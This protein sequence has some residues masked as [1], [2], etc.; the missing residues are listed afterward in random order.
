MNGNKELVQAQ[1]TFIPV[2]N[3]LQ[4]HCW[5]QETLRAI[6]Q[7]RQ[8]GYPSQPTIC[9]F[10]YCYPLWRIK[11]VQRLEER[12]GDHLLSRRKG[13]R[14]P[15]TRPS[16]R[17]LTASRLSRLPIHQSRRPRH[18][19]RRHCTLLQPQDAPR[20]MAILPGEFRHAVQTARW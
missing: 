8:A 11:R 3:K 1:C 2:T 14:S 20:P 10:R 19:H 12:M 15:S 7:R 13:N 9:R 17:P 5:S 16:S 4:S 18:P 6:F